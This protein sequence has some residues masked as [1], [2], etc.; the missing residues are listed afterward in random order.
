[1]TG[2]ES[3]PFSEA[4]SGCGSRVICTD[5]DDADED[6][7]A[8][9]PLRK[10]SLTCLERLF[11]AKQTATIVPSPT[12]TTKMTT[13]VVVESTSL[14]ALLVTADPVSVLPPSAIGQ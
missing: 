4:G 14:M 2:E 11:Q 12:M 13:A 6:L 10:L 9:T 3:V 7:G 1:M 5:T 8:A